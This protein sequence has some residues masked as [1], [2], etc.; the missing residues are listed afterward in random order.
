MFQ[1]ISKYDLSPQFTRSSPGVAGIILVWYPD[2]TIHTTFHEG[3]CFMS[4]ASAISGVSPTAE[5]E[6]LTTFPSIARWSVGRGMGNLMLCIPLRIMGIRLSYLVFGPI[7][8]VPSALCYL[9]M[10]V[11]GDKYVVTNRHVQ[12]LK[13]LGD[14]KVSEINLDDI[15]DVVPEQSPGQV[16][17]RAGDLSIR[18]GKNKSEIL[19]L[20]SVVFP[21][22]FRQTLI[23]ARDARK[24]VASSLE[25]IKRRG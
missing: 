12:I 7:L 19:R 8:A 16:W 14:S 11:F 20:E 3:F 23:D 25:T 18:G 17:F 5:A 22:V 2:F 24:Q 15:E 4:T 6:V 21:S 10:K 9:W 1:W 13:V